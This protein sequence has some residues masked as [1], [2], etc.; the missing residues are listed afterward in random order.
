MKPEAP[1]MERVPEFHD[2]WG[3]Q[4]RLPQPPMTV[5]EFLALGKRGGG[6]LRGRLMEY[7]HLLKTEFVWSGAECAQARLTLKVIEE[8][9]RSTA[10]LQKNISALWKG[11]GGAAAASLA[12]AG[13]SAARGEEHG[14]LE[15]SA[16]IAFPALFGLASI[17]KWAVRMMDV[18]LKK[19]AQQLRN[20]IG[21]RCMPH[22][23]FIAVL[24]AADRKLPEAEGVNFSPIAPTVRPWPASAK[25][26]AE[27]SDVPELI[28]GLFSG[29]SLLSKGGGWLLNR[30]MSLLPREIPFGVPV[31]SF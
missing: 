12:Y 20:D 18:E 29:A 26:Y 13:Y 28:M 31:P 27:H 8:S 2:W 25:G 4:P 21:W 24:D 19:D 3:K 14:V 17:G 22:D 15:I 16:T 10:R 6:E 23:V 9:I 11:L 7:L 1:K 30:S 5:D